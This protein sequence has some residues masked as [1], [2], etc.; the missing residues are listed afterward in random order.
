MSQY[1]GYVA[2]A[3]RQVDRNSAPVAVL[4]LSI[5]QIGDARQGVLNR[6]A[7]VI[8]VYSG[9]LAAIIV[10]GNQKQDWPAIGSRRCWYHL[11]CGAAHGLNPFMEQMPLSG[12]LGYWRAIDAE[13]QRNQVLSHLLRRFSYRIHLH[14]LTCLVSRLGRLGCRT[15]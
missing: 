3:Q 15:D 9:G 14:S 13:L 7:K 8:Y 12:A 2:E 4:N 5:V 1:R 6:G 10:V 11:P